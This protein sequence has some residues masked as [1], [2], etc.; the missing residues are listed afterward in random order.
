MTR[1]TSALTVVFLAFVATGTAFAQAGAVRGSVIDTDG[2][3]VKGA[4]VRAANPDH[5]TVELSSA[6]DA[7]GRFAMI[8]LFGGVWTF[9][10]EAPGFMPQQS[11]AMV[12]SSL[13]ANSPIQFVLRR[14]VPVV[15]S[16]ISRQFDGDLS[17]ANALRAEGR[18]DQA[19][20]AYQAMTTKTPALSAMHLVI[21]DTWRQKAAQQSGPARAATLD[22]AAAAFTQALTGDPESERARIELA[23]TE[24]ARGRA[25]EAEALVARGAAPEASGE[26]VCALAEVRLGRGDGPGAE[27]LFLHAAAM[28]PSWAR[29]RLQLG[30]IALTRGDRAGAAALFK[31]AASSAESPEAAEARRQLAALGL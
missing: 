2:R 17:A 9:V 10:A 19:V 24:L 31:A 11:R 29:P 16:A 7:K 30:V 5:R 13:I 21:G 23:L 3:P 18:Y 26:L 28:D 15:D 22:Q 20:A 27:A 8:G 12:R 1:W 4:I 6:S 25:T 14:A